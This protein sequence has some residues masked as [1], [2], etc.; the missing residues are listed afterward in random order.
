LASSD[1]WYNDSQL[2]R[3]FQTAL[4]Q[5]DILQDT[6]DVSAFNSKPQRYDDEFNTW[7]AAGYPE[8]GDGNWD[9]FVDNITP[10]EDS[11]EDDSEE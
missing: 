3:S 11:E 1:K 6:E 2:V 4:M 7:A 10:D 5:A 8:E 9:E